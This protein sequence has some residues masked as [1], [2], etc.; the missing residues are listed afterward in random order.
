MARQFAHERL[1]PLRRT[2]DPRAPLSRRGDRR[3]GCE[4]GFFGMLVPEAVGW[5]RYRLP[6]LCAWRW[7]RSP[8]A[9]AP[10]RPS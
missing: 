4:L 8:P 7:R 6:R 10:A 1:K 3:D 9:T 2:V 5:Q